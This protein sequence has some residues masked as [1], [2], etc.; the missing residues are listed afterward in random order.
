M[1]HAGR[2]YPL[3]LGTARAELLKGTIRPAGWFHLSQTTD[4]DHAVRYNPSMKAGHDLMIRELMVVLALLGLGD[5]L[6]FTLAYYGRV[7]KARWVPQILC[8][9]EGSSCVTV[10]Q[11]PYARVF[12]V[13]NS[14][15]GIPYYLFLIGW[16]AVDGSVGLAFNVGRQYLE[17]LSSMLV[18]I[19]AVTVLVGLY[20]IYTLR[21][22]LHVDCPL[23][24]AAHGI[25]ATLLV[26]ILL[27]W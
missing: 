2:P 12:G 9:G 19:S 7:R 26:L 3:K 15:L 24:Y 1:A 27:F 4:T 17:L 20:L 8:A 22:K 6:Y 11:T 23:C 14:L 5:A 16:A 21:R 10:V 13:P 25:N 18:V